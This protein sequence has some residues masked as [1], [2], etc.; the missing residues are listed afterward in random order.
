M[1][2]DLTQ[3]ARSVDSLSVYVIMTFMFQMVLMIII[4]VCFL[5][6]EKITK[7]SETPTNNELH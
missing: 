3:V 1:N 6:Y 5:G 2:C 7:K 4:P